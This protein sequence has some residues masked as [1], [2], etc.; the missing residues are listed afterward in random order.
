MTAR[1]TEQG[2][3]EERIAIIIA[4]RDQR[5]GAHIAAAK[6]AGQP[7]VGETLT[8]EELEQL[9][10]GEWVLVDQVEDTEDFR[11]I[12]GRLLWH[13]PDPTEVE[14]IGAE[15]KPAHSAVQPVGKYP[16]DDVVVIL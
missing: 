15:L 13:S 7:W 3:D 10:D 6:A 2:G 5:I 8:W 11:V 14:R 1:R 4:T 16:Y 9:F 12:R